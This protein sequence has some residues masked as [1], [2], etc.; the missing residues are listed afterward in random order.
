MKKFYTYNHK[1]ITTCTEFEVKFKDYLAFIRFS[2]SKLYELLIGDHDFSVSITETK[3]NFN[4]FFKEWLDKRRLYLGIL[5][6]TNLD[7]LLKSIRTTDSDFGE[8][9]AYA[10]FF[11]RLNEQSDFEMLYFYDVSLRNK[12]EAIILEKA[13]NAIR[14][15]NVEL[16]ARELNESSLNTCINS[17]VQRHFIQ[18]K[19]EEIQVNFKAKHAF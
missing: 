3:N 11:K 5:N 10:I 15:L 7:S 8:L 19:D 14:P 17:L 13:L 9:F 18:I 2:D 1:N 16:L 6:I 12:L 4:A